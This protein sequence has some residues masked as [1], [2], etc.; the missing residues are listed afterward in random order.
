MIQHALYYYLP[1]NLNKMTCQYASDSSADKN[2]M[3][4]ELTGSWL[5]FPTTNTMGNITRE[6]SALIIN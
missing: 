6:T 3:D 4:S 1:T 2:K 5:S